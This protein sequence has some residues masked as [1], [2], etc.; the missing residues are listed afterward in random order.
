MQRQYYILTSSIKFPEVT[1]WLARRSVPCEVHLNRTRFWLDAGSLLHTEMNLRWS[2]YV[3]LV[4]PQADLS[5]GLWQES[6]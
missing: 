2:Q 4:D 6:S 1:A 5:T 3:E